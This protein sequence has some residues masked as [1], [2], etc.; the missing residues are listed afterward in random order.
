MTFL[1][2]QVTVR[3]LYTLI[4]EGYL[5]EELFLYLL[6]PLFIG[7]ESD[8]KNPQKYIRGQQMHLFSACISTNSS[9]K[10][11]TKI[12]KRAANIGF[13]RGKFVTL[14]SFCLIQF[15]NLYSCN[16]SGSQRSRLYKCL[17]YATQSNGCEFGRF[18]YFFK[19]Q[20]FRR[21][22]YKWAQQLH[23]GRRYLRRI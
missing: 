11:Y 8:G 18:R 7:L 9:V 5:H 17:A 12:D 19:E 14:Q 16:T 6:T 2:S 23:S 13:Q 21:Y 10:N 4:Q 3:T 15:D 22:S 1:R 20:Q